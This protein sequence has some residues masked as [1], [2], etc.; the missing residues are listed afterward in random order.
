MVDC[1]WIVKEKGIVLKSIFSRGRGKKVAT[2]TKSRCLGVGKKREITFLSQR[3]SSTYVTSLILQVS[4]QISSLSK[5]LL[6]FSVILQ[7]LLLSIQLICL[8]I[9]YSWSLNNMSLSCTIQLIC[10]FFSINKSKIFG[11]VQQF[12]KT[13]S[14]FLAYFIIWIKYIIHIQNMF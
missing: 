5:S 7:I 14:F 2:N 6:E 1:F 4:G 13:F 9:M 10:G 8:L 12:G 11:D 3:E